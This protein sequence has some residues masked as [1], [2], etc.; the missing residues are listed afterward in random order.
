MKKELNCSFYLTRS[1]HLK[2]I[3]TANLPNSC[4]ITFHEEPLSDKNLDKQANIIGVFKDSN[5]TKEKIEQM[6]DLQMIATLCTGYD[7]I[8][9]TTAQKKNIPVCNAPAYGNNTVAEY[10][11]GLT[12]AWMRNIPQAIEK[13]S[14][15]KFN[16]SGL[17][18]MELQ[19]KTIGIIGTGH[20]GEKVLEKLAGFNIQALGFDVYQKDCLEEKFNFSYCSQQK[21]LQ[22]SDIITLHTPLLKET[23]H[24]IDQ[25]S[26]EQMKKD[27][28]LVNTARGGLVNSKALLEALQQGKIAGAALDV[29]EHEALLE[30]PSKICQDNCSNEE[31]ETS[32]VSKL[33]IDHPNTIITPHNAF[34]SQEAVRRRLKTSAKNITKFIKGD[35]QNNVLKQNN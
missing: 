7:N 2:S 34:N 18:G 10:T 26:F 31:L 3:L 8:D 4:N 29:I 22:N 30:D 13:V 21:L 25:D 15:G 20:I 14:S 5:V 24:M 28:L 16:T 27:A 11:I 1:P 19:N 9:T 17:R 33:I 32:L 6:E 12:L 35:V 23:K